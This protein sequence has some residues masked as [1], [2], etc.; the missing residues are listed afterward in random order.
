MI[1][2]Q[3]GK[4]ISGNFVEMKETSSETVKWYEGYAQKITSITTD[5]GVFCDKDCLKQYLEK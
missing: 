2:K 5:A 4:A 3:C 1:C